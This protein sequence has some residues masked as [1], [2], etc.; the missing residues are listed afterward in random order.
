MQTDKSAFKNFVEEDC[1][2]VAL[3]CNNEVRLH[4]RSLRCSPGYAGHE[5]M[6]VNHGDK[7]DELNYIDDAKAM[8]NEAIVAEEDA[9]K[10]YESFVKDSNATT[11]DKTKEIVDKTE[12]KG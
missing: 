2:P 12:E 10:G 11:E 9:Q 6:S 8:E 3:S 4:R 7:A 5:D 1:L